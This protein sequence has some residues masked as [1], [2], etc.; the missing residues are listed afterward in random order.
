MNF[1]QPTFGQAIGILAVVSILGVGAIVYAFP[2]TSP[3]MTTTVTVSQPASTVSIISRETSTA[4]LLQSNTVTSIV[5]QTSL[6]ISTL[7]TV[8]NTVTE[9]STFTITQQAP[10]DVEVS[11]NVESKTPLTSATQIRFVA[12]SGIS[13][14]AKLTGAT[15]LIKLPN[16]HLYQVEIDYS[17]NPVGGGS[18]HAGQMLLDTLSLAKAVDWSC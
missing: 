15:Y 3:A 12:D 8:T 13:Y 10:T 7:S 16:G 2:P 1:K 17:I 11:G 4:T 6:S 14:P 18:C 5:T 9:N